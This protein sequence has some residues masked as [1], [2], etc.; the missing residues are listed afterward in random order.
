MA[1]A[2]D[3]RTWGTRQQAEERAP[4]LPKPYGA[5]GVGIEFAPLDD[6]RHLAGVDLDTCRD[7]VGN[8]APWAT[9]V[10]N[11]FST[12]TEVSP[13]GSGLKLFFTYDPA[14][15]T[16]I[17]VA[18]GRET[19]R[20][21]CKKGSEHPPGI[22]FYISG[23][24]FAVTDQRHPDAPEELHTMTLADVLWL[25]EVAG[26]GMA[27]DDDDEADAAIE[28]QERGPSR[29]TRKHGG[30]DKSRSAAALRVGAQLRRGGKTFDEMVEAMIL[31]PEVSAWTE[32]KG[33]ADGKRE[34]RRIWDKAGEDAWK[35]GWQVNDEGKPISN[36]A[37]ALHAL[38]HAGEL[39][40]LFSRDAMLR[41][42]MM[43][44]PALQPVR[45]HDITAVQETIQRAGLTRL[46]KDTM[47]QAV[48]RRAS[49]REFHPVHDYLSSLRW[50]G[51]KRL[52]TWLSYYLGAEHTAYTAG[53][54]RM[55]LIAMVA[56]VLRPGCKADYMMVLEGPQGARKS[57]ACMILAGDWFSDSLPDLRSGG[58]DVAQHLNGKWLIEV[59]EMSALDKAEA[60]A[61][62]AFITRTT[63]RYR[64]SFGR[65]EV[66]EP[67]QCVFIGTTN[68]VAYLRDETG[69]R[70]FWPVS[71]T[72]IDIDALAHDRDQLL[73]E[74]VA[75]FLAGEKWWPDAQFELAHIK[76]EQDA[77]YEADAWED[78]IA[79]YLAE[80]I[81]AN[82]DKEK[83]RVTVMQVAV[84]G[85]GFDKP[86]LGTAEQRR[87]GAALERRGWRRGE[88]GT[89]GERYWIP[90][91]APGVAK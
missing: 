49:E 23:R 71:V 4:L 39:R 48:Q 51:Q 88:R 30:G 64:P 20:K 79:S 37:N 9:E 61:L 16:A 35:E 14:D 29:P 33:L 24:F 90:M 28:A 13:S 46:S 57:T 21:W 42:D 62:K 54:G 8:L 7:D 60:A 41:A 17:R 73:A 89:N 5:G 85:L 12:Y 53:I 6:A 43:K 77:R 45:D 11:R 82:A 70:R 10:L 78:A 22:E 32:E 56:R 34:L 55:F 47:H 84:H 91:V 19:G 52:D 80:L 76:P 74:A 25:I 44:R 40:D 15:A 59:A 3:G 75:A 86:K 68:K 50:D 26:P 67:R 69:G 31:D 58:K 83:H 27:V 1:M 18:M 87:V 81:K 2:N 66:I 72:E 36:L 38:R 65:A 63:E